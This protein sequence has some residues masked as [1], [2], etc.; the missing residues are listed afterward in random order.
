MQA[1]GCLLALAL[2]AVASRQAAAG[3]GSPLGKVLELLDELSGKISG[4]GGKADEAYRKYVAWCDDSASSMRFEIKSTT[5]KKEKLQSSIDKLTSQVT[6]CDSKIGK[7]VESAA[8]SSK[9]LEAATAIRQK[10]AAE[11]EANEAELMDTVDTLKRAISIIT[12]EMGKNPASFAQVDTSNFKALMQSLGAIV[13][14]AALSAA[15]KEK[16][17]ALVQSSQQSQD[18][19]DDD[20]SGAP[21]G[22]AYK[23]HSSG[24]VDLMED[25]Q[26]KAEEDLNTLRKAEQNAKQNYEMLKTSLEDS[27]KNGAKDLADEK[28]SKSAAEEE[29]ASNQKDLGIAAKALE[30][31]ESMLSDIK[32]ECMSVAADHEES[33]RSRKEELTVINEAK[34]ALQDSTGSALDQQGRLSFVQVRSN[35]HSRTDLKRAEVLNVV[36]RLAKRFHSSTLTQLA[37]RIAAAI[38]LGGAAGE[39][40]F[41]KVKGMIQ[42]LIAKLEREASASAEEKAYCDDEMQK[43]EEKK[44]ELED[45]MEKVTAKMDKASATSVMLKNEVKQLQSELAQLAGSQSDLD[46]VRKEQQEEYLRA[47]KEFETGQA[48]VRKALDI[49]RQYYGSKEAAAMLQTDSDSDLGD[50]MAQPA[51]PV[52]HSKGTGAGNGIIGILEVCVSDFAQNLAKIDQ[53]EEDEQTYYDH[54]TQENKETS[55]MKKQDIGYKTQEFKSLDKALADMAEDKETMDT[56]LKA[57][58]EYYSKVKE[59][60]VARP[61]SYAERKTRREAEVSGLKEALSILESETA[62]V[63]V[64]TKR[65][66]RREPLRP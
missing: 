24:L 18:S 43:T 39:D 5:S 15:S 20:L 33:V 1:R 42:D 65:T 52:M 14:A 49:L 59:R 10:E 53:E 3:E 16:L 26:E 62:L 37:S 41:S 45:D 54:T 9:D 60:C 12:K 56:Q 64:R 31:A 57:V 28:S 11:F 21:A 55:A 2:L 22:S 66:T 7:L 23:S 46:A 6:V 27:A 63:Q 25:L 35:L 47:K 30:D 19:A 58:L 17:M 61:E 36:K 29:K 44:G 8:A 38:K 50:L 48:S 40:P 51:K 34:K 32:S 13:D 4:E